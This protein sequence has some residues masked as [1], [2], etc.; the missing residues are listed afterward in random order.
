MS[1]VEKLANNQKIRG[2]VNQMKPLEVVKALSG[3]GLRP[4][5]ASRVALELIKK[6][7]GLSAPS[8][9]R[10][11]YPVPPEI[12]KD[13]EKDEHIARPQG[14]VDITPKFIVRRHQ[15]PPD[16]SGKPEDWPYD[17]N[18]TQTMEPK[19]KQRKRGL[20]SSKKKNPF[21]PDLRLKQPGGDGAGGGGI[22]RKTTGGGQGDMPG[23][24][25]STWVA[26]GTKGWN[27]PPGKEFDTPP[28]PNRKTKKVGEDERLPNAGDSDDEPKFL[29]QPNTG[30]SSSV[31]YL[32]Y[33]G[34]TPPRT[35]KAGY[36][37]Y[38]RR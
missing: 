13:N 32:G 2:L 34:R 38:R 27:S 22:Y 29:K 26:R 7:E 5:E 6:I 35:S 12:R 4:K 20:T 36:R 1:I 21:H 18:T 15:F 23:A 24:G 33:G 16:S 25:N 19:N 37:G 14:K 28:P 3:L 9:D 11:Q 10:G 31:A 17:D 30:A 8:I